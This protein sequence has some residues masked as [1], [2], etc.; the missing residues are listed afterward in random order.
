MK[1]WGCAGGVC[2]Y[3]RE[4]VVCV[5]VRVV[6]CRVEDEVSQGKENRGLCLY[7]L[8]VALLQAM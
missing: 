6:R 4:Y 1:E 8:G 5:C 2:A 3:V 7:H